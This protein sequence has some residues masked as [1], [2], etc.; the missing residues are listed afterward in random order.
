VKN[1]LDELLEVVDS[2]CITPEE[3]SEGKKW[4]AWYVYKTL[5]MLLLL[6]GWNVF[7]GAA[8]RG[9]MQSK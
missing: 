5:R 6:A 2:L 7:A 4:F 9:Y 8:Y 1:I 3:T